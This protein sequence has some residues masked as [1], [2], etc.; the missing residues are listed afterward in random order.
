[1]SNILILLGNGCIFISDAELKER[2]GWGQEA[3]DSEPATDSQDSG[4]SGD[5][6]Y[7]GTFEM[8]V[9]GSLSG[10]DQCSGDVALTVTDDQIQGT[11]NCQFSSGLGLFQD[12]AGNV[13]GSV[14]THTGNLE[15]TGDFDTTIAWSGVFTAKSLTASFDGQAKGSLETLQVSGN[16]LAERRE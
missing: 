6:A 15:F 12:Q 2:Q 16:F 10:S 7:A 9:S 11:F 14:S 8:D 1:M 5:F 3:R 4:G 13:S